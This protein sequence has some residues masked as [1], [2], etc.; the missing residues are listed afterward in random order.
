MNLNQV[1]MPSTNLERSVAFYRG[2]GFRLIVSDPPRY[3]RFECPVGGGTFSLDLASS[4]PKGPATV[5]YFECVDV[6][7]VFTELSARGVVFE[8][9]P[10]DQPWLWREAY[11]RDPDGNPLCLYHAGENRRNPP[12]RVHPG[13]STG[14]V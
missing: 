9:P 6:D 3:A 4:G 1:T 12:W 5:V 14:A 8:T 2:L 7:R 10:A 11:L 13:E